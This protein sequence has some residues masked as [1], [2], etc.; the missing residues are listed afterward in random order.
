VLLVFYCCSFSFLSFWFL[1][2]HKRY[3][4]CGWGKFYVIRTQV[5]WVQHY[6]HFLIL[7]QLMQTLTKI[8]LPIL[9]AFSSKLLSIDFQSFFL[10]PLDFCTFHS[11]T[12]LI[13]QEE[14]E[15]HIFLV[16]KSI[17]S[18]ASIVEVLLDFEC[19]LG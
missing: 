7:W 6:V 12:Q 19:C 15:T 4:G 17:N 2:V 14:L 13:V 16:H 1:F 9:L 10:L 5:W 3:V 11:G 8:W 18:N